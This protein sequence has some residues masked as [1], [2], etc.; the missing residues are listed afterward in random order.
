M[1]SLYPLS[2]WINI[3]S[4]NKILGMKQ[5]RNNNAGTRAIIDP[6]AIGRLN[7]KKT[8]PK[9]IGCRTNAYGPVEMTRCCS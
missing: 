2:S 8:L 3:L 1:Y 7:T 4:S 9:Y 6:S 5:I